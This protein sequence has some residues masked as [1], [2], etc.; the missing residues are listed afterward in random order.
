MGLFVSS[1]NSTTVSACLDR[2]NR[3]RRATATSFVLSSTGINQVSGDLLALCVLAPTFRY[4]LIGP[5]GA[6]ARLSCL[7][8]FSGSVNCCNSECGPQFRKRSRGV[9]QTAGRRSAEWSPVTEDDM[10]DPRVS[11]RTFPQGGKLSRPAGRDKQFAGL[12]QRQTPK[13][14]LQLEIQVGQI[15]GRTTGRVQHNCSG[16][17]TTKSLH[18]KK[19][20]WPCKCF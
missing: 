16:G 4:H 17:Q 2:P 13:A 12:L 9:T 18:K 5:I 11:T 14:K 6:P 3:S 7:R 15:Q 8:S 1:S 20:F 10:M 19:T